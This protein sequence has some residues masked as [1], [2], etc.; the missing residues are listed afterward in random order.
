[1]IAQQFSYSFCD[2]TAYLDPAPGHLRAVILLHG[3]G[4]SGSMWRFQMDA[5][6]AAGYRPIA[7]DLPGFG[8]SGAIPRWTARTVARRVLDLADALQIGEFDL[9]GLSMGGVIAQMVVLT[10]PERVRRLVLCSTFARLRPSGWNETRYLLRRFFTANLR[11]VKYQA[12]M[13][14]ARV[15]PHPEQAEYRAEAVRQIVNADPK[16]YRAAMRMLALFNSRRWVCKILQPTL[17]ISGENDTTVPLQLQHELCDLISN[18]A[19]EVIAH[20]NHASA[21]D[22]PQAFNRILLR[23]L[24]GEALLTG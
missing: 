9:V 16:M 19:W 13:V 11:G 17:V 15:F 20:A 18:A 23:F 6:C 12:G 7:V 14:A 8:Q 4:A 24:Q 22:Q 10:A 21:V 1:M 3:L 5:L 2:G